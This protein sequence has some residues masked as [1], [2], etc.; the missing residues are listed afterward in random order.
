MTDADDDLGAALRLMSA[1]AVR[2]RANQVFQVAERDGLSH[3]SLDLDRLDSATK[4][5]ASV[6]RENYPTLDVP[7]HSRWRHFAAGGHDRWG[8]IRRRLGNPSR[9]EIGRVQFDFVI[10]SVLLDAGAGDAWRYVESETGETFTRSEG[11]AVA[12]V[13]LFA[14]G[15][16]SGDPD[17]P[18]RVDATALA[19][20]TEHDLAETF[21][22]TADNPL[23]GMAGR[24]NLLHGLADVVHARTDLFGSKDGTRA[25]VGNL[26]DSLVAKADDGSICASDVLQT[27]LDG[28]GALWPGRVVLGGINLG[29]TWRH[30]AVQ[31]DDPSTGLVPFH[32]LSQWL[33]YSLAEPLEACGITVTNLDG[34]TGLAEYRN[35]GLFV[36]LG[37]LRPKHG[38]V[39]TEPHPVASEIVV[40]W[41]A[42]TVALL[43][44]IANP[45]RQELGVDSEAFPLAKVLE[46]GTWQA[47]RRIAAERRTG[48]GPPIRILSEGTVF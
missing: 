8:R 16:L 45:L 41:R 24:M 22:V 19:A 34:L 23:I 15:L 39:T 36:D 25:R 35:G 14:S 29:D 10:V 13:D 30:P 31:T 32:K 42:L 17:A 12:S 1:T 40:E 21:Q 5:V 9:A 44:R 6:V 20:L 47:G 3:F 37:V 46:G 38:L 7:F 4:Y 26:L 11:L 27:V 33:T 18:F 2:D 28:L 43:D 48:G